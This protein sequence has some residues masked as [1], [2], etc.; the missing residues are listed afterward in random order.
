MLHLLSRRTFLQAAIAAPLCSCGSK[1]GLSREGLISFSL[2]QAESLLRAGKSRVELLS[3]AGINRMVGVVYDAKL[4]DIVVVGRAESRFPALS[5]DDLAAA[6]QARLVHRAWPVVSIDRVP[7]TEKTGLQKVRWEGGVESTGLGAKLLAADEV[8][9]KSA[10]GLDGSVS[11]PLDSYF[12]LCRKKAETGR[13]VPGG[14]RFWFHAADAALLTRDNVFVVENLA[15]GIRAQAVGANVTDQRDRLADEYAAA[16]TA[17][18]GVASSRSP[19]IAAVTPIF[20]AVALAHGVELLP[21]SASEFWTRRYKVAAVRT[22]SEYPLLRRKERLA[23]SQGQ[24]VLELN[25][26]VD[27]QVFVQRLRDQDYLAF[28][29]VVLKTRPATDVLSWHLPLSAWGG[30]ASLSRAEERAIDR[31]TGTTINGFLSS[32]SATSAFSAGARGGIYADV[33]VTASDIQKK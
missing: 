27:T 28:K 1:I 13:F 21:S 16:F 11:L 18:L 3:V 31:V 23:Q 30:A 29:E 6:I 32:G 26:G 5:L 2:R 14:R 15:I 4:S 19:Q 8:L 12:D 22:P 33:P 25:G 7:D 20:D 9:K 24:V 10:L 17:N